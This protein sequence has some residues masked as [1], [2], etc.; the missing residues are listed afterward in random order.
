MFGHL[1]GLLT[2]M[3]GQP[4][5]Y[6][7]D[8]QEDKEPLF[9]TVDTL[10]DTLRVFV[11]L[12]PGVAIMHAYD[13]GNFSSAGGSSKIKV[14]KG[15]DGSVTI[16]V[17]IESDTDTSSSTLEHHVVA[18]PPVSLA[19]ARSNG[20]FTIPKGTPNETITAS[21]PGS[22]S[23]IGMPAYWFGPKLQNRTARVSIQTLKTTSHEDDIGNPREYTTIY[24]TAS[25]PSASEAHGYASYPGVGDD[26]TGDVYVKNLLNTERTEVA[27]GTN[28]TGRTATC[29]SAKAGRI[30][31]NALE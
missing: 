5:A 3:K 15:S 12:V 29:H 24:R 31:C 11:E 14:E 26:V 16:S 2:L 9:D 13:A 25:I 8:N 27:P 23:S 21:A 20:A 22:A 30:R 1:V 18:D 4:L 19:S 7:K 17:P 6:N 28:E 10:K